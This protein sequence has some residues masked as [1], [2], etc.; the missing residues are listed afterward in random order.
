MVDQ[1]G[2]DDLIVMTQDWTCEHYL[3][4]AGKAADT[5]DQEAGIDEA[6]RAIDATL[7]EG[8]RV[9]IVDDIAWMPARL[10][11]QDPGARARARCACAR[12]PRRG[13]AASDGRHRLVLR[14]RAGG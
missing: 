9:L 10:L 7:A 12:L 13:T 4:Y 11:A 14:D 1:S 6:R 2:P 3:R 5:A 8:G